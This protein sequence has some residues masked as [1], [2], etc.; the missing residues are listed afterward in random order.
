M[1]SEK[2]AEFR[3]KGMLLDP[4]F[5]RLAVIGDKM[6]EKEGENARITNIQVK[7]DT[8]KEDNNKYF[9]VRVSLSTNYYVGKVEVEIDGKTFQAFQKSNVFELSVFYANVYID[10]SS[11]VRF[12]DNFRLIAKLSD[13]T[14]KTT[15]T[16]SI[17][18]KVDNSGNASVTNGKLEDANNP[19]KD[20]VG[21]P[22]SSITLEQ[23]IAIGVS[24]KRATE[25]IDSL[26]KTLQDYKIDTDLKTIHF[27]A[28]IMSESSCF[29]Y[30]AELGATDAHYKGFKGR[31]LIQITWEENYS[32]YEDYEGEDFTS[33]I[34]NKQKLEKSPYAIRSAG[35]FW[36]VKAELN[37]ESD[38]NDF[39]YCTYK[40]NGGFNGFD[41]RL[42][43]LKNGFKA[44]DKDYIE[45]DFQTSKIYNIQKACFAWG[46]WNDPDIKS[47]LF[48]TCG[49]NKEFAI[50]GYK[51]F[52]EL[53]P[54]KSENTNWYGINKLNEFKNLKFIKKKKTYVKLID[55]AKQ[56]IEKL[57]KK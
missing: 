26:N 6:K 5:D 48:D 10:F 12:E 30:T 57:E 49:S 9:I 37:D 32:A 46:L 35:W 17:I 23:L 55:A 52:L 14:N 54:E 11:I 39:I 8:Q 41:S 43:Y 19:R 15:D 40:V 50:E 31:G 47:T 22:T 33:S 36:G 1:T 24:K 56:R 2:L 45:F 16:K 13:S 25:Y 29:K 28:Q 42:K 21:T 3:D 27:L 53:I 18:V 34:E 44:L 51:R 7:S 4:K 20:V 38:K